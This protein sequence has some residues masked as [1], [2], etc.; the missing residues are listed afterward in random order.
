MRRHLWLLIAALLLAGAASRFWPTPPL[1]TDLLALL[2]ATERNPLAEQ[3][4]SRL[5]RFAGERAVFLI[6]LPNQRE[7]RQA[8][9]RLAEDLCRSGAFRQ[10]L[11][12]I[13][14]P[15][16]SALLNIY[17][18]HRI[19]LLAP[20][21]RLS[22]LD[23]DWFEERLQQRLAGP[24][25]GSLLGLQQDPFG[26]FDAW[27]TGLPFNRFH[28]ELDDGWLGT[29]ADGI[30]WLLVSAQLGGSAFDPAIQEKMRTAVTN[31]ERELKASWPDL[32]LLR[33]GAVFH[34]SAAR[35]SAEAEM[36][37]IGGGSLVG[38]VLLLLWIYR[39]LRPLA[40]GVLSIAVGLAGGILVSL[41]IYGRLHL[42]TL[43]FG[44]SLIGEAVDYAVQYFSARLGAGPH[45]HAGQGRRMVLPGLSVALATSVVGYTALAFTPFPA[46]RQIATFSIS[47][48]IAAWLFV[49][50]ALPDWLQPAAKP[51]APGLLALPRQWLELWAKAS[52]RRLAVLAVVLLAIAASGWSRLSVNDDVRQLIQPPPDLVEQERQLRAISG[53]EAGSQ[54]F[55]VTGS[56]AEQVLQREEMLAEHLASS[57]LDLQSTARFVPS[58]RRQEADRNRLLASW[59]AQHQALQAFGFRDDAVAIW[60]SALRTGSACLRPA[61]WLAA[62][63][64]APFRH[65]WFEPSGQAPVGLALPSGYRTVTE[66]EAAAAD[67]PGVTL[68]DKPGA[69]SRL[70][71]VYRHLAAWAVFGA[72]LLILA[73]LTW[74]YRFGGGIAILLPTWLAQALALA[75]LGWLGVPVNLFNVLALL[76]VLG[77][78][79]NYSIFLIEAS[80]GDDQRRAAAQLGVLL[81]AS[82]TLLS[83]GLLGLSSTPALA[84]FGLTL[85]MGITLAVLLAP[86]ALML[87]AKPRQL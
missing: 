14:N 2:P 16:P 20:E 42:M 21:L 81:S 31:S 1:E 33:A 71:G 48:L 22:S 80:Q 75:G 85:A 67:L 24:L 6:G 70:F 61:A 78:G 41:A 73:V 8:A 44:A 64:S 83:F 59:P 37:I 18:P 66:L 65:L 10:C 84:G 38:T 27:L 15:D 62:P 4:A 52:R 23:A 25:A 13:P 74:R 26:L 30:H 58:C 36:T 69:V 54:F 40:L 87:G 55:L 5:S 11:A 17:Q 35:L 50:I 12:R 32:R 68:V 45:W 29:H 34:A 19:G 82:T 7:A 28:L 47:G 53:L 76:L 86:A 63:V 56:D 51:A 77:V 79:I 72:S 46:L 3:A 39:S 49:L 43:V 60:E 57:S 9:S